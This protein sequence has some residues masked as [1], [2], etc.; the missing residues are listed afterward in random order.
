MSGS[1]SVCSH[2]EDEVR[3]L[4]VER[5]RRA[6]ERSVV[7]A[8]RGWMPERLTCQLGVVQLLF[9]VCSHTQTHTRGETFNISV[10]KR[11]HAHRHTNLQQ[12]FH[13]H[14]QE[15]RL[16]FLVA[17]HPTER[18]LRPRS[19]KAD[20]KFV[21]NSLEVLSLAAHSVLLVLSAHFSSISHCLSP[22]LAA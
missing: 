1:Q 14:S 2:Q 3:P 9:K 8:L 19:L 15:Q 22:S 17:S 18:N 6:A 4:V 11:V 12:I 20:H 21:W 5:D 13:L 10:P 7:G 16:R